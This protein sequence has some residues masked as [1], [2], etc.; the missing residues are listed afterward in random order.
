MRKHVADAARSLALM[1]LYPSIDDPIEAINFA[2]ILDLHD[3]AD[4]L[5]SWQR[6]AWD[7][8]EY[9]YPL[10]FEHVSQIIPHRV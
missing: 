4:F 1:K 5:R 8:I 7:E 10:F 3:C 6:G 2:L 9:C